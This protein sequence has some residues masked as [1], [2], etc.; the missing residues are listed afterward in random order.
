MRVGNALVLIPYF[1]PKPRVFE[2]FVGDSPECIPFAD[3]IAYGGITFQGSFS[4]GYRALDL[5]GVGVDFGSAWRHAIS[6]VK[7]SAIR[8]DTDWDGEERFFLIVSL[9]QPP[10]KMELSTITEVKTCREMVKD[11]I[12]PLVL[13]RYYVRAIVS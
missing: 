12:C 13:I 7:L 1:R 9:S 10:S 3:F 4:T 6:V 5:S 2:E 8:A 11:I